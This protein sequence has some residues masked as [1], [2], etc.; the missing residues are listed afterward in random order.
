ME[1]KMIPADACGTEVTFTIPDTESLGRLKAYNPKFSL[2]MRYR[3][4]EDW[5]ALKN[6]EVRAYYMG[7]KVIPNDKGEAV[8]CGV[9]VTESECF[10]SAQTTLIEAVH[11]LP[12]KTP[13]AIT[14][15]ERRANKSDSSRSTCVFDVSILE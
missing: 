12:L 2:T 7:M 14:Y 3:K 8:S 5:A 11:Q 10:L 9:F 13:V 1:N 4:A 15:R 6:Q